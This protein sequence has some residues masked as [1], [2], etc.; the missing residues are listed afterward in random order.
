MRI[1]NSHG[2]G[3]ILW[4]RNIPFPRKPAY[5]HSTI[6]NIHYIKLP[7]SAQLNTHLMVF[8]YV[9]PTPRS[10]YGV[11][12]QKHCLMLHSV[13]AILTW[14]KHCFDF[15]DHLLVL[16]LLEMCIRNPQHDLLNLT[17]FAAFVQQYMS[18][19]VMHISIHTCAFLSFSSLSIIHLSI[20]PAIHLSLHPSTR[21]S[22][23]LSVYPSIQQ[24]IYLSI[25]PSIHPSFHPSIHPTIHLSTYLPL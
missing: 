21:L 1:C 18:K 3:Q 11:L 4:T 13:K 22:I 19:R 12:L 10:R 9:Y 20:H 24:Y 16:P 15:C 25:H 17:S 7:F 2:N 6:Y 8:T 14:Y 5:Q 23:I